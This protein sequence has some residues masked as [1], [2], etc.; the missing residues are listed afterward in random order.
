MTRKEANVFL[1]AILEIAA[2]TPGGAPS[3]PMYAAM[4]G[5]LS[6]D[7]YQGL[8]QIAKE[9][10]LV[11]EEHHVVSITSKGREMVAKIKAARAA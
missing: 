8:V 7:D 4:M 6:L 11:T 3:G 9:C 1:A 2:E 10:D 5:K